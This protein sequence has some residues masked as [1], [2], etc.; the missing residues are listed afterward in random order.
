MYGMVLVGGFHSFVLSV[1]GSVY[2]W[3]KN[4]CGQLGVSDTEDKC[5]PTQLATLRSLG[6]RYITAGSEHSAFLTQVNKVLF[7]KCF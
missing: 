2:G 4:N 3:G 7:L 5:Q 6:V 1:S